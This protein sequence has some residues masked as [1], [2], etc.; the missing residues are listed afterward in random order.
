M[1][2]QGVSPHPHTQ[3][4]ESTLRRHHGMGLHHALFVHLYLGNM[5]HFAAANNVYCRHMPQHNP[6]SR[7]CVQ[8]GTGGWARGARRCGA[9]GR[10]GGTIRCPGATV[11]CAHR[12]PGH[13]L[14]GHSIARHVALSHGR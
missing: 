14:N 3:A 2:D 9:G 1:Q 13:A 10:A 8:V 12:A 11:L 4:L 6:P 5:G 7:A